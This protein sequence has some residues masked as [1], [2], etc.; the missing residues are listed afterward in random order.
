MRA[1]RR[2]VAANWKMHKVAAEA[3]AFAGELGRGLERADPTGRVE[4]VLLPSAPLLPRVADA[5]AGFA[6]VALGGQDLHPEAQGAHT[7]DTSGAQLADCGCRFALCGHSERR[8]SHGETDELVARKVLAARRDGLVP[9]LCVGESLGEREDGRTEEVLARQLDAALQPV[10]GSA[11]LPG[12]D[13]VLAYEPIWAIG[14]G[15]TAT[16]PIVQSAHAFL[17]G[18]LLRAAGDAAAEVRVLYGGSVKA[19]NCGELLAEPDVDGFLVGGAS[20][21]PAAFL[22]IIARCAR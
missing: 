17:R 14:T 15:R 18:R 2:L 13:L 3:V 6:R 21:D 7:G 9:L 19:E 22:G 10:L 4:V 5:L 20:L 16:P 1:R 11:Q 12:V 8:A